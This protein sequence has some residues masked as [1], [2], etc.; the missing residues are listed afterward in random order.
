MSTSLQKARSFYSHPIVSR[1]SQSDRKKLARLVEIQPPRAR[2][3]RVWHSSRASD[4]CDAEASLQPL[5]CQPISHSRDALLL[6]RQLMIEHRHL[7]SSQSTGHRKL[8][9]ALKEVEETQSSR[10]AFKKP[11]TDS[12]CSTTDT[13]SDV[14]DEHDGATSSTEI[15]TFLE[16][17]GLQSD[18]RASAPEFIPYQARQETCEDD[19][20]LESLPAFHSESVC[21]GLC[22][23]DSSI[24]GSTGLSDEGE[25]S[26]A[27]HPC[28]GDL[29]DLEALRSYEEWRQYCGLSCDFKDITPLDFSNTWAHGSSLA[30][31]LAASGPGELFAMSEWC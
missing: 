7:R 25:D 5:D 4:P 18:L 20:L 2:T 22:L 8:K 13:N 1:S 21:S 23:S 19:F 3:R 15:S 9:V 10:D 29:W 26:R 31:V 30:E 28:G 24:I 11:S 6:V 16:W 12:V 27:E 14:S 17:P